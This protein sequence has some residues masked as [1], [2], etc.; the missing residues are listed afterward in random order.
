M[1]R[2]IFFI[3]LFGGFALASLAVNVF[4]L[5][6][7]VRNQQIYQQNQVNVDVLAFR[8][9]FTDKVLLA[10]G[11][12]DFD[13]RLALETSVRKLADPEIFNQWQRFTECQTE[14]EATIQAK[15]LLRLLID[16]TSG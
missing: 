10:S 1:E 7:I 4:L 16:K 6:T 9:M 8:N 15:K 13:T 2:K 14:A 12:I 11:E 5:F 3:I